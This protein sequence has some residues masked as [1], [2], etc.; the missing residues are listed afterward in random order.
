M[1]ES[2]IQVLFSA[3]LIFLHP[4]NSGRLLQPFWSVL[5]CEWVPW[6]WH[7]FRILKYGDVACVTDFH[8]PIDLRGREEK[9]YFKG[10]FSE[11]TC[12][13]LGVLCCNFVE[14][15]EFS[16][17]SVSAVQAWSI[18]TRKLHYFRSPLLSFGFQLYQILQCWQL[19]L[20]S[21]QTSRRHSTVCATGILGIEGEM[22]A[23]SSDRRTKQRG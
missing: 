20:S 17:T 16:Y 3:L 12:V 14:L 10:N 5:T 7:V 4:T 9:S 15:V 13:R 8:L 19:K 1:G 6:L 18:R 11:M 22:A 23:Q 21:W 2:H